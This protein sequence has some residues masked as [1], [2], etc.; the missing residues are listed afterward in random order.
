M[1]TSEV[2]KLTAAFAGHSSGRRHVARAAAAR[3]ERRTGRFVPVQER[4][5]ADQRH[6]DGDRRERP[7]R[8]RIS[9]KEDFLVYEDDQLADRDAFQRRARAGQPRDRARHERQHGGRQ[10]ARRPKRAQSLPLRSARPRGRILPVQVQQRSGPPPGL[11]DRSRGCCRARSG[12]S[13][14][15]GGTAMY[16]AVAEAIPMARA[17]ARTARRRWSSSRTATTRRAGWMFER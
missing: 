17:K 11:D 13:S 8:A 5:R 2:K 10:D 1:S 16:D 3:L 15:N 4:G 9:R 12:A 7:I 14:P 6:G